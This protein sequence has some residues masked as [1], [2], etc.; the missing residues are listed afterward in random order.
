MPTEYMI[1]KRERTIFL[2]NRLKEYCDEYH[3]E[4]RK[5]ATQ[6][7]GL[8]EAF[9]TQRQ[10]ARSTSIQDELLTTF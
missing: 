6:G 1:K 3:E 4:K 9:G 10:L 2:G 8:D 7:Q 5:E